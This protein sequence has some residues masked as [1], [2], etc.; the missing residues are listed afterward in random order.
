MGLN[1]YLTYN[2]LVLRIDLPRL[3]NPIKTRIQDSI[4]NK[5]LVSPTIYG[6]PLHGILKG[7]WKLRVGDY[8]VIYSIIKNEIRIFIIGHRS[9][10]YKIIGKR[11]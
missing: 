3:D 1:Y 11:M 10:V 9:D 5:L 7:Y 2:P 6:L 4:E 8:R